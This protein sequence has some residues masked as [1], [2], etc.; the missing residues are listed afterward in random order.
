MLIDLDGDGRRELLATVGSG[1]GQKP[2]GVYCFD[3]ERGTLL[4]N[5][6]MG[7]SV[8]RLALMDV[9]SDGTMDVL[10]G[11]YSPGN[12]SREQDGTDDMHCYVH[13]LSSQGQVLW[14][15]ELGG[16]FT[17]AYPLVA[18]LDGDKADEIIV[19]LEA[20]PDYR[21]EVG[22]IAVL[23]KNGEVRARY[24]AQATLYSCE[25]ADLGNDSESEILATDRR[26]MLHVL[27]GKLKPIAKHRVGSTQYESTI[28]RIQGIADLDGDGCNE[29]VVTCME[30]QFVSGRNPRSD[31]GPR[32]VRHFH[33]NKVMVLNSELQVVGT[34][35]MAKRWERNPG[36]SVIISDFDDDNLPEILALADRAVLLELQEQGAH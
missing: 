23:D 25:I 20:G 24:D 15:R 18:D 30:R 32:N 29:I 2:R 11:S 26:G 28:L 34:F 5:H 6:C 19:R 1:Y 17:G 8:I 31:S 4:W 14:I 36:F 22:Q 27:D 9:N 35:L 3:F 16:H 10:V 33:N 21:D 13:A 7:P 12:G